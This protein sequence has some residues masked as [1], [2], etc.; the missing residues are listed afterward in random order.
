MTDPYMEFNEGHI[1]EGM[2]RCHTVIEM[3]HVL[4][5]GHPAVHKA[6][7]VELIDKATESLAEAYQAIGRIEE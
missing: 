5:E 1:H 7:A 3:I 4:L 2:D 6:G